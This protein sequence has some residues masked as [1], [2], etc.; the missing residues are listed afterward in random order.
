MKDNGNESG[1]ANL[2]DPD[3][4]LNYKNHIVDQQVSN[5]K[6]R[7]FGKKNAVIALS[8]YEN[9]VVHKELIANPDLSAYNLP[10][11][12]RMGTSFKTGWAAFIDIMVELA[13]LWVLLPVGGLVWLVLRYFNKRKKAVEVVKS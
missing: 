4:L 7:R 6:N 13:N 10:V 12:T 5:L 2:K 8:F 1:N 11:S 3:N 9:Y